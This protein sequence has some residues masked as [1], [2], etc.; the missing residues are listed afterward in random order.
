V[1]TYSQEK[2][3]D[4]IRDILIQ[5]VDEIRHDNDRTQ[6]LLQK[7]AEHEMDLYCEARRIIININASGMTNY[8][9]G[10]GF[11]GTKRK[12]AEAQDAADKHW[13]KFVT[14]C[15]L[16]GVTVATIGEDAV[17]YWDLSGVTNNG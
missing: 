13:H 15:N 16:G 10:I 1:A 5:Y 14:V 9:T 6:S 4:E 3:I 2:Q 17:S 11:S 8:S 7:E 12:L